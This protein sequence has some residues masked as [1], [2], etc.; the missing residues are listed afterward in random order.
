MKKMILFRM[1]ALLPIFS[2]VLASCS[3]DT[4][5]KPE[6][7]QPVNNLI[8]SKIAGGQTA[9]SGSNDF[10]EVGGSIDAV[11]LPI[12][13]MASVQLFNDDL[14]YMNKGI[15]PD[16]NGNL[17]IEGLLPGTYLM[18]IDSNSPYF[19]GQ[20]ITDITVVADQPTDL[21]TIVLN[22]NPD[23]GKHK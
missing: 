23:P 11:I 10:P 8:N 4:L 2:I 17:H 22:S 7:K 6:N 15:F 21:G 5:S 19:L 12:K 3:K 20:V 13:A 9:N 18:Q 16:E 1:A 14:T